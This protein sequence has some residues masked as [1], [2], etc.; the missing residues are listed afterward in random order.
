MTIKSP[1]QKYQFN[2]ETKRLEP[3]GTL[4]QFC[5][6]DHSTKMDENYF[7]TLYREKDRTNV[8]VYRS[9]KFSAIP[10]GIPRCEKCMVIHE[11]ASLKG[12]ALGWVLAIGFVVL[13]FSLFGLWGFLGIIAGIVLGVVGS[14]YLEKKFVHQKRIYTCKEAV[15]QNEAVQ[16]LVLGGW[17]LNRPMA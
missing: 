2:Q 6:T 5:E 8:I 16:D 11:T 15:M 4:C 7:V 9:V 17:S 10:V 12:N 3:L 13:I 1:E 14:N